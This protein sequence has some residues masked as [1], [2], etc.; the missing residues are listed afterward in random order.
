MHD[1]KGR[2]MSAQLVIVG[3]DEIV[4]NKYLPCITSA[5]D[6]GDLSGY[7]IIDLES[8]RDIITERLREA[9]V[10]PRHVHYL[11]NPVPGQTVPDSVIRAAFTRVID[12]G[13]PVRAYIATEVKAHEAYLRFCIEN[14]IDSLVEKPVI[15]PMQDGRFAP[16]LISP[17]MT[18]LITTARSRAGARHSVMTLSRYHRVYNDR[19]L[20][21]VADRVAQWR[22]PVTSLHLRCAGGVW[23]RLDEYETREDHPYKYGYG[24]M[25]HGAYHYVDL[26]VQA[27]R[28]NRIAFPDRRFRLQINSFAAN[29]SDQSAR[30]PEA[31]SGRIGDRPGPAPNSTA[32]RR[33]GETDVTAIFRLVDADTE[34][35]VTVGTLAFEQTTPSVRNWTEF[36]TGTYNKNGRVSAV[37][38][39]VGLSTLFSKHV[40][41]YD[42]PHGD[43]DKI[44]AFARITTRANAA[45][46]PNES[47]LGTEDHQGV[48]HS[49]SNR[50]LMTEWLRGNETRSPLAD[51]LRPMQVT[52]AI[53]LAAAKPGV[54]TVI[55]DF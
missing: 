51:H 46:H 5:I 49:D 3:F 54:T 20:A 24:M 41:C 42:I 55:E 7:S 18:D 1:T 31:A 17:A 43:P 40:H 23:N 9:K 22:A 19:F 2:N 45:L 34:R 28:M 33:F 16:S 12:P 26:M 8:E 10:A 48:F 44:G 11:P 27:L 53:L 32:A 39:E 50:A 14:R 37:D 35:T 52:E 4:S 47:Y 15:A 36:P 25:L 13:E 29:P 30:I 21:D 6:A 38:F